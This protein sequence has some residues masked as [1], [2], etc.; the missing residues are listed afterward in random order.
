MP[1]DI[2]K[3]MDAG[4]D[5]YVVKPIDITIFLQVV[6]KELAKNISNTK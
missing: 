1:A 5:N 3:G 4:F 2:Q 6:C